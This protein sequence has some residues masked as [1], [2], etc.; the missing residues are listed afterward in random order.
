[1]KLALVMAAFRESEDG[2]LDLLSTVP[3]HNDF[4]SVVG[5][6]YAVGEGEDSDPEVWRR[7]GEPVA[8]RWLAYRAVV[9]S[10]NLATN[11]LLDAVGFE[12]PLELLR[13]LGCQDS[14]F[15]RGIEDYAARDEGRHNLVTAADLAVE[16]QAVATGSVLG[17]DLN[18]ELLDVLAAQQVDSAL[19][20]GLPPGTR[21]AHKSGWVPGVEHDAGIVYPPDREPYVVA[22]C[23]TTS[24]TSADAL[25]LIAEVSAAAYADRSP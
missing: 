10:S 23:T 13:E 7:M 17:D 18:R 16:L 2:R 1:M 5:G 25:A 21:I 11:L 9:R 6:S 20:R 14:V 24:L 3:V 22:V 4:V 15:A 19:P 8:L 12:P